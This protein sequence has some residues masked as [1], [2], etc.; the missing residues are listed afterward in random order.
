MLAHSL[1]AGAVNLGIASMGMHL[2][3][4][5]VN[6]TGDI[7]NIKTNTPPPHLLIHINNSHALMRFN[8]FPLTLF[9]E[10]QS[11]R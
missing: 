8:N 10:N 5:N 4:L 2:F 1:A 7:Q 9:D 6:K 11:M 3:Y